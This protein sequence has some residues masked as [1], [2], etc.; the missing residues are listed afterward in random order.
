MVITY[1]THRISIVNNVNINNKCNLLI[2]LLSL[3]IIVLNV[4]SSAVY[5]VV[6]EISYNSK[7]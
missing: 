5:Q 6:C 2:L 1:S 7:Y 3:W 4:F